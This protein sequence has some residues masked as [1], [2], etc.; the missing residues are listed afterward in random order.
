MLPQDGDPRQ[1]EQ[2]DQDEEEE[3]EAV[4]CLVVPDSNLFLK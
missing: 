3:G 2:E 4:N 1:A